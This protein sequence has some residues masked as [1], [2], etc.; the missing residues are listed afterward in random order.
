MGKQHL[1]VLAGLLLGIIGF[2]S[3]EKL[4]PKGLGND[5]LLDGPVE[6]LTGE[7]NRRFL[8]GDIAFNDEIFTR[9]TGLGPLFVA[10]VM[11]VMEKDIHFR[12]LRVLGKATQRAICF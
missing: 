3:C 6:G 4:L 8:N 7:E 11:P 5:Q 9:E 12:H 2:L 1:L 10:P